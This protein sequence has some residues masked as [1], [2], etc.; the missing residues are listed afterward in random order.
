MRVHNRSGGTGGIAP[1]LM[2]ALKPVLVWTGALVCIV[3]AFRVVAWSVPRPWSGWDWISFVAGGAGLLLPFAAFAGGVG[4]HQVRERRGVIGVAAGLIVGATTYLV[5]AFIS[6]LADHAAD[7]GQPDLVESRRFGASTPIGLLRNIR[8]TEANPPMEYSL[9]VDH[10]TRNPPNWLWKLLHL[11]MALAAVAML[12]IFLG[13]AA[14]ELTHGLSPPAR[15]NARLAIGLVGA[16]AYFAVLDV[17][18][19]SE[20]DWANVSGVLAAWGPMAVPIAEAL[21][22][23]T[24]IRRRMTESQPS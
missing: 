20:R 14:A 23:A 22:L 1:P 5:L 9:S 21:L 3:V 19:S 24:I 13:C 10:P 8:Y 11:D 4:L 18:G 12:N 16:L 17:A 2:I 6:P 15:R 7:A